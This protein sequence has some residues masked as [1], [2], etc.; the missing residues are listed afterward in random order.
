MNFDSI[1]AITDFTAPSEHALE[2]AAL[3]AGQHGVPLRLIYF[4]EDAH[5]FFYDPLARLS[6]RARQL[7]RRHYIRV[8]ALQRHSMRLEDILIESRTSSLLVVGPVWRRRWTSIFLRTGLDH[9]VRESGCPVLV[10]KQA[11]SRAYTDVL[12][13]V[14]LSPR[15]SDLIGYAREFANPSQ[16]K[17]FHA[18]DTVE[19]SRLR[20]ADVSLETVRANRMNSRGRARERLVQL[21]RSLGGSKSAVSVDVGNGDPAYQAAVEQQA[22]GAELVV[23]GT[24]SISTLERL[25]MGSVA[26]RLARWAEG[27]VLVVPLA[28]L[29]E[30]V[31]ML[32]G[33]G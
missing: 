2:R 33:Q 6:Q 1:L 16:V 18:I 5:P 22:S 24:R 17:L 30:P 13:A 23:V 4:A 21:M 27:D 32:A 20:L 12:V 15:S 25:F 8:N 29:A 26:Q 28:H 10:V 11:A 14:D 9:L 7:A 19:E 31:P 3:L